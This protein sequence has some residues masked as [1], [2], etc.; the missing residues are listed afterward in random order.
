MILTITLHFAVLSLLG[1]K[2]GLR[3]LLYGKGQCRRDN[4]MLG[5]EKAIAG[6][7]AILVLGIV[8][9]VLLG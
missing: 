3:E 5:S 9:A 8:A 1:R 7:I 6:A 2:T 4:T